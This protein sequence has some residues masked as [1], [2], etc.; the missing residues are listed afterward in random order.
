[1]SFSEL[2][3]TKYSEGLRYCHNPEKSDPN[4]TEPHLIYLPIPYNFYPLIPKPNGAHTWCSDSQL[5][6]HKK[7]MEKGKY[8]PF[9]F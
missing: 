2:H 3:L 4:I 8:L 7:T 9:P 6:Q 1:M 5:Y